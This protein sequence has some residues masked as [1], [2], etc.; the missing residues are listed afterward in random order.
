MNFFAYLIFTY[1]GPQASLHILAAH[2]HLTLPVIFHLHQTLI[3]FQNSYACCVT[4]FLFKKE[5][6]RGVKGIEIQAL[7]QNLQSKQ[8][9]ITSSMTP[10]REDKT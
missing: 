9:E 3:Y 4:T 1:F 6:R 8:T 7:C 2:P 10:P 5:G